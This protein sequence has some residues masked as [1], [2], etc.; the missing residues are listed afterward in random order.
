MPAGVAINIPPFLTTSQFTPEQVR[1]T[2]CIARARIHIERAIGRMK[3]Y[4]IL[5]FIPYALLPHA[6]K[7]FQV[8]GA[9]TNL[10][11]PLLRE[12]EQFYLEGVPNVS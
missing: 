6:D 3:T 5:D 1:Q 10:Q 9:L 8:I 11:N 7:V 12:V 4:N 2:E